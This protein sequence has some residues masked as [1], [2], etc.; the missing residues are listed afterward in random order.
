MDGRP[1]QALTS[2]SL[3]RR[4]ALQLAAGAAALG[5]TGCAPSAREASEEESEGSLVLLSTQF[6]PVQEAEKMR[7]AVLAGFGRKIEFIADELGPFEDRIRAEA[8]ANKGTVAVIGGQHGDLAGLA[9]DGLLTDLSDLTQE[10]SGRGFHPDYLELA[11]VGGQAPV[12]LPWAQAS[13]IMVAR[14]QAVDLLPSGAD[15]NAL[16][17]EQLTA[18]GERISQQEGSKRLGFPAGEEGLLNRFFQGY[19]YPSFT[20]ALNTRF[21]S[22]EAERMWQW[23]RGAWALANPQSTGYAFMQEPLQSG[24][25]WVAWDHVARLIEAL[26]ASPDDFVAFPAPTGPEGLGF[27]PVLAGLAIPKTAP[28]VDGAKDLIRYLTDPKQTATV[29]R[30]LGFFPPTA[31]QQ[32]PAELD[33][34][35]RAEAD[36]IAKMSTSPE[37]ITSLLPVG[38]KDKA[39]AYGDVFRTTFEGIVLKRGSDI[40]QVLAGKAKEL[41]G[42]LDSVEAACWRPDPESSGT[43]KVG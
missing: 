3:T 15:L 33:P 36:A 29:A 5:L 37:A 43:C 9:A 10:L 25:A 24:E 35:I 23:M 39:D 40:G 2:V 20:G 18:W 17:Y 16:T 38:L 19:A 32:L 1:P 34:G 13:Y 42:V 22:A 21:S 41:Q 27:I 28:D 12:Y 7:S 14:R 4:Q 6:Q 11:K 30:E 8:Q 26:R 31:Q